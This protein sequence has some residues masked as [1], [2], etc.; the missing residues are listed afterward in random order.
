M[1]KREQLLVDRQAMQTGLAENEERI[2]HAQLP[3]PPALACYRR[4]GIA[5][6]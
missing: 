6:T 1:A 5:Q 4:N 3:T 2:R